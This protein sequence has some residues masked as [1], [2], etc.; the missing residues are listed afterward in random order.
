[1]LVQGYCVVLVLAGH[2]GI[3]FRW[4][5]LIV[6]KEIKRFQSEVAVCDEQFTTRAQMH[7]MAFMEIKN[8]VPAHKRYS[9]HA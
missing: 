8:T 7:Q 9:H 2:R 6:Y 4:L 3:L 5:P 1:M